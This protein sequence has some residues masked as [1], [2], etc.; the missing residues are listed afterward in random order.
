M[1]ERQRLK[2]WRS[3]ISDLKAESAQR[4]V[5][6][7]VDGILA[8]V[9]SDCVVWLKVQRTLSEDNLDLACKYAIDGLKLIDGDGTHSEVLDHAVDV[10]QRLKL[11]RHSIYEELSQLK[12][13]LQAQRLEMKK[14][15]EEKDQMIAKLEKECEQRK[16][17]LED[18]LAES[19]AEHKAFKKMMQNYQARLDRSEKQQEQAAQ[20]MKEITEKAEK[21]F[22]EEREARTENRKNQDKQSVNV[23]V[24]QLGNDKTPRGR[25]KA[26]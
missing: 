23:S 4:E 15:L 19:H 17:E 21:M 1:S 12:G 8:Y 5:P 13:E 25:S 16:S 10:L 20:N 7:L 11:E 9:R 2:S 6:I 14:I 3:L 26:K 24:V 18:K 22:R